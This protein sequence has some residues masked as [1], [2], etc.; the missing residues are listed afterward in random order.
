VGCGRFDY[1]VKSFGHIP[2]KILPLKF[3]VTFF[4]LKVSVSST[5]SVADG[6]MGGWAQE[7]VVSNSFNILRMFLYIYGS[8]EGPIMLVSQHGTMFCSFF[9]KFL[10][11]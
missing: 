3:P 10:V 1:E 7:D 5:K 4:A 2:V 6:W 11:E 9:R 8:Q